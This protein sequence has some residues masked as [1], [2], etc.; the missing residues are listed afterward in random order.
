MTIS[1]P[2]SKV[3]EL[4]SSQFDKM[5]ADASYWD[6]NSIV[7]E[8]I[9]RLITGSQSHWLPWLFNEYFKLAA[10]FDRVLSIGCGDGAHEL[11]ILRT[12]KVKF[13]QAFDLSEGAVQTARKRLQDAGIP[14]SSYCI[15]V[16]DANNLTEHFGKFDL[17]LCIASA[18]HISNLEGLFGFVRKSLNQRAPFILLEFIGPTRFQWTDRQLDLINRI[19]DVLDPVYVKRQGL[20]VGRPTEEEMIAYDPSEAVRSSDIMAVVSRYFEIECRR[21]YNGAIIHQLFPH[22]NA[23]FSDKKD[24]GFDSIIRLILLFEDVITKLGYLSPDFT[25]LVCR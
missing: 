11:E 2:S 16:A 10:N 19:L 9:Y 21:D 14:S 13:L 7:R 4:W 6:N 22:L 25:L 18:H 24:S 15:D 12:G 23:I 3:S 8:H 17:I 1:E 5:R 20:L